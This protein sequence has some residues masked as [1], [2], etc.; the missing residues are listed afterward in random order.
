[1]SDVLKISDRIRKLLALAA[2]KNASP[3]EVSQAAAMA[4]ALMQEHKLSEA[5]V[6]DKTQ[7]GSEVIDVPLGAE[8]FMASWKFGLV[9]V[10]A[11]SF[12]CEAIGL[13]VGRRRKVRIVGKKDDIEVATVVFEYLLREIERLTD[14]HA[15]EPRELIFEMVEGQKTD[16][17]RRD[18]YRAGL[19]MGVAAT[20]RD[21]AKKFTEGSEKALV[22]VKTS[23]DELRD[24]VSSKFGKPQESR[25]SLDGY[26]L[27]DLERGIRRGKEI[28]VS[29]TKVQKLID[30]E[31][32]PK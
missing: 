5:D 12:F 10:T 29:P 11:R 14:A 15:L 17:E 8:G 22:L 27:S 23:Q 24:H 18:A 9:T 3:N 7:D 19:V 28:E 31:Q 20:L 13:H 21:Q 32:P 4:A 26:H 30:P 16:R 6:T 1:M 25:M 2:D